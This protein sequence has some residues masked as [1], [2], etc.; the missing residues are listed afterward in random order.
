MDRNV[1]APS[2]MLAIRLNLV[3]VIASMRR[4]INKALWLV[5]HKIPWK[6]ILIWGPWVIVLLVIALYGFENWR[7][8][9]ALNKAQA[10]AAQAGVELDYQSYFPPTVPAEQNILA[11]QPLL[12]MELNNLLWLSRS[13]IPELSSSGRDYRYENSR[14]LCVPDSIRSWLSSPASVSSEKEAANLIL[15][16]LGHRNSILQTLDSFPDSQI[17]HLE[18]DDSDQAVL[19][20]DHFLHLG[21]VK[22]YHLL[23]YDDCRLAIAQGD[24][25]RAFRR[26]SQLLSSS[27]K[28][29]G[30]SGWLELYTLI[31]PIEK[32]EF[33]IWSALTNDLFDD[34]QLQNLLLKFEGIDVNARVEQATRKALAHDLLYLDCAEAN[35]ETI[36]AGWVGTKPSLPAS[37]SDLV[38]YYRHS[39]YQNL[40]PKG[41]L[42][43][44]RAR[45]IESHLR[46][47][48]ALPV[49]SSNDLKALEQ[50]DLL[51]K[52]IEERWHPA[53]YRNFFP[54]L[55]SYLPDCSHGVAH[56]LTKKNIAI[57]GIQL[58]LYRK[59]NGGYP[60]SLTELDTQIPKDIFRDKAME[61]TRFSPTEFT[62]E[63]TVLR[64]GAEQIFVEKELK[65]QVVWAIRRTD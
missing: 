53:R 7:G 32:S 33:L 20:M 36:I 22:N 2:P 46:V 62:L 41:W 14:S 35:P 55:M 37:I 15:S 21:A 56:T 8:S 12:L 51:N 1:H 3:I 34:P 52:K 19:R 49:R 28:F 13:G 40:S 16:L 54:Y 6:P 47:L 18:F 60:E 4:F 50:V 10:Q 59:K 39:A 65:T 38:S 24:S 26:I 27:E 25:A 30:F 48:K 44:V 5:A 64:R 23:C 61:Y 9:R 45:H 11:G 29:H 17:F 63:T 58:E 57:A 42:N 31:D 43:Q